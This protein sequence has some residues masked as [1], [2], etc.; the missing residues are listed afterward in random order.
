MAAHRRP[1]RSLASKIGRRARHRT[2]AC[3]RRVFL[4]SPS[5]EGLRSSEGHD[6][7]QRHLDSR[8]P[9]GRRGWRKEQL[10]TVGRPERME[11]DL[12]FRHLISRT[13]RWKRLHEHATVGR[14][15]CRGRRRGIRD[16]FTVWRKPGFDGA[17]PTPH[18][19]T[20]LSSSS[21]DSMCSEKRGRSLCKEN[22]RCL[23]SGDQD[24]GTCESPLP[25]FVS[26]SIAPVPSA[27]IANMARSPSRSAWKATRWP[28]GAQIGKRL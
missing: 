23:P 14:E 3:R 16:P 19:R 26:R 25:G 27:R 12:L 15:S 24:P 13:G 22:A 21:I 4:Q 9:A 5:L 8:Q 17:P 11:V 2:P 20:E 28:S 6:R 10:G 18:S 1:S 7:L